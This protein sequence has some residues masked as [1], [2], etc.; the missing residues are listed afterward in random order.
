M[1]P[2]AITS[3]E[4][5]IQGGEFTLA[6]KIKPIHKRSV[7]DKISFG[8]KLPPSSTENSRQCIKFS[9]GP[10]LNPG[11]MHHASGPTVEPGA[12]KTPVAGLYKYLT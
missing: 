4:V 3:Q 9:L 8:D 5:A 10:Y 11:C 1:R 6:E 2:E 7:P 12:V